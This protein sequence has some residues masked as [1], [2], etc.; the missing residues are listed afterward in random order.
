MDWRSRLGQSQSLQTFNREIDEAEGWIADKY[1]I[2]TDE[3]YRDP[4]NLEGKLQ[5]HDA[6][7]AEV[8]ANK[9]RMYNLMQSGKG[10]ECCY[11]ELCKVS[12]SCVDL[13][14]SQQCPG[15]ENEIEDRIKSL[16]DQWTKLIDKSAEKTQK[17]KEA[18][19]EQQFNEG[20]KGTVLLGND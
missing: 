18:N 14:E 6:F 12:I 8:A 11:K 17:L 3:S 2:A 20:I 7:E 16:E 15:Q 1:Q 13:I 10:N 9:E 5:K 19:Q 4:T